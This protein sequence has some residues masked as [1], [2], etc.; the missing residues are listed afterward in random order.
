[1]KEKICEVNVMKQQLNKL[2]SKLK[3]NYG[4]CNLCS[5]HFVRIPR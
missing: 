4:I 2:Q 1:M 5:K 3:P